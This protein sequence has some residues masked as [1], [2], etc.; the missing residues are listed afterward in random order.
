M[1]STSGWGR[2][3]GTALGPAEKLPGALGLVLSV[4]PAASPGWRLF[5]VQS[6]REPPCGLGIALDHAR[7]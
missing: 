3:Q 6:R 5:G 2:N 4:E 7:S 1:A